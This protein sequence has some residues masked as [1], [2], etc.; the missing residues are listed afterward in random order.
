MGEDELVRYG[1]DQ[2]FEA[3]QK[4]LQVS[5][6]LEVAVILHRDGYDWVGDDAQADAYGQENALAAKWEKV[7]VEKIK[8]E[9]AWKK[10]LQ[11]WNENQQFDAQKLAQR[12]HGSKF[13]FIIVVEYDQTIH[14]NLG[15]CSRFR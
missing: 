15:E 13:C 6:Q 7:N 14:G 2:H 5:R 11:E 9:S 10:L 1:S 8:Q 4:V 12:L 3:Y